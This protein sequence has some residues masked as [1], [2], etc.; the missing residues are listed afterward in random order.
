VGEN[1]SMIEQEPDLI[2]HPDFF[3]NFLK[4]RVVVAGSVKAC[5]ESLGVSPSFL[6]RLLS[7]KALPSATIL[8][9][10]GLVTVYALYLDKPAKGKK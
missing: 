3:P 7:G 1:Q 10:L 9:K 6:H 8:K 5:A 4:S 2:V